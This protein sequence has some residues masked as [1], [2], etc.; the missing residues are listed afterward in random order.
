[1]ISRQANINNVAAFTVLARPEDK[2]GKRRCNL[3]ASL[4]SLFF[5]FRS[6]RIFFF[7]LSRQCLNNTCISSLTGTM[8]LEE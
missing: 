3:R 2:R 6:R 4:D 8:S 7:L 1:M 5:E